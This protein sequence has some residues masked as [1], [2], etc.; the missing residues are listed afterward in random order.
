MNPSYGLNIFAQ[1]PNRLSNAGNPV[2][3]TFTKPIQGVNVNLGSTAG[4]TAPQPTS[5]A[6]VPSSTPPVQQPQ[7]NQGS[8]FNMDNYKGWDPRAAYQDFLANPNK[9]ANQGGGGGGVNLDEVYNPLF[10]SLSGQEAESKNQLDEAL[11]GLAGQKEVAG[12]RLKTQESDTEADFLT[13]EDKFGNQ[14]RSALAEAVRYYNALM[15][16]RNARF[17]SQSSAGMAVTDIA[18][19]EVLRNQGNIEQQFGEQMT[20]LFNNRSFFKRKMADAWLDLEKSFEQ[21]QK[22]ANSE[23]RNRLMQI[24]TQKNQLESQ[25]AQ[26]RAVEQQQALANIQAIN[27]SRIQAIINLAMFAAQ[28]DMKQK[29]NYSQILQQFAPYIDINRPESS[30][31]GAVQPAKVLNQQDKKKPIEDELG[32]LL[33]YPS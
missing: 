5:P 32:S 33:I 28:E 6:R 19:Q 14:K 2:I 3:P 25:K 15:Q 1:D 26:A 21:K 29:N 4:L 17:G 22:E 8:G 18:N 30:Q 12:N 23:Y 24:N 13:E 10:S 9:F 31:L 7:N 16:Q 27:Q 20:A 11:S